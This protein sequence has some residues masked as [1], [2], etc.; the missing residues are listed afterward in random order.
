MSTFETNYRSLD[1]G[2]QPRQQIVQGQAFNVMER[3][4]QG[5]I[6]SGNPYVSSGGIVSGFMM[7]SG[8]VPHLP[9]VL[10]TSDDHSIAADWGQ[11][12]QTSQTRLSAPDASSTNSVPADW[13]QQAQ[14]G[15]NRLNALDAI[16]RASLH[17][18]TPP[19][20]IPATGNGDKPPGV[21]MLGVD[22]LII[23]AGA[24]SA[25]SAWG[26]PLVHKK[27]VEA[28]LKADATAAPPGESNI[29]KLVAGYRKTYLSNF[30]LHYQAETQLAKTIPQELATKSHL[31][32]L[33]RT[34]KEN[35]DVLSMDNKEIKKLRTLADKTLKPSAPQTEIDAVEKAGRQI[36]FLDSIGNGPVRHNLAVAKTEAQ[37]K[38]FAEHPHVFS[39]VWQPINWADFAK[40]MQ[41]SKLFDTK[42]LKPALA[43][44]EYEK[45]VFELG[46]RMLTRT[47]LEYAARAADSGVRDGLGT[48][49]KNFLISAGVVGT[50]SFAQGA[51][52]QVLHEQNHN[53]LALL[54]EPNMPGVIAKS[55]ALMLA[56]AL[57]N[58][59][60]A[61]GAAQIFETETNMDHIQRL[62]TCGTGLGAAG[63]MKA[64]PSLEKWAVPLAVADVGVAFLSE[65]SADLTHRED[66]TLQ[67]M[68]NTMKSILNS[69]HDYGHSH[70]QDSVKQLVEQGKADPF[71]L[72]QI[73]DMAVSSPSFATVNGERF[74]DAAYKTKM[75]MIIQQAQGETVLANGFTASQYQKLQLP[76]A[77]VHDNAKHLEDWKLLPDEHLDI[78]GQG[79]RALISA[80]GSANLTEANLA[81][82]GKTQDVNEVDQQRQEIKQKLDSFFNTS[83]ENEIDRALHFSDN[84][85]NY[86]VP[87]AKTYNLPQ[88]CKGHTFE[89]AHL[90]NSVVSRANTNLQLLEEFRDLHQRSLQELQDAQL[91]GDERLNAQRTK[92]VQARED[93]LNYTTA[94]TAKLY[95]DV[96]LLKLGEVQ[97]PDINYQ[98]ERLQEADQALECAAQLAPDNADLR[99]LR[100]RIDRARNAASAH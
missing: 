83:H 53:G 73:Y 24:T 84:W 88:F 41:R 39:S 44:A 30:S 61:Y 49:G 33:R 48:F 57:K 32:T 12:P 94:Y 69:P 34:V 10:V 9:T 8:D 64:I 23:G 18:N 38:F 20:P 71:L 93:A 26:H 55:S 35:A 85:L 75:L 1:V 42:A 21:Q 47:Q 96:A 98:S 60:L 2:I 59:A 54:V 91:T 95:R 13:G 100:S 68:Q 50:Q 6:G 36:K 80:L 22:G 51:L 92:F 62:I 19:I 16:H 70:I 78:A 76:G 89:Y 66:K 74:D 90:T 45:P 67:N 58:K 86:F 29:S 4:R 27:L 43:M 25:Y 15:Q 11:V 63:L 40:S 72:T 31:E 28:Q 82:Q 17:E 99:C 56:P 37:V 79:L 97:N 65:I 7:P 5:P 87:R 46:N 52:A 14:S 77:P 3:N 81:A